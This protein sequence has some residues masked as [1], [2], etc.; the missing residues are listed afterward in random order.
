MV[1]GK[2]FTP[3]PVHLPP[4]PTTTPTAQKGGE[5]ELSSFCKPLDEFDL[6]AV[7]CI[8]EIIEVRFMELLAMTKE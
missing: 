3:S 2:Y 8:E 4:S 1:N 6:D 7:C 5:G